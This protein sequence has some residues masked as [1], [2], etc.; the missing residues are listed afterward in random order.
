MYQTHININNVKNYCRLN[1]GA[2]DE[3]ME[4]FHAFPNDSNKKKKLTTLITTTAS[5]T[6]KLTTTTPVKNLA[7]R[8]A[9]RHAKTTKL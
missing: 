8:H 4:S 1:L 7:I 5:P 9:L 6:S 2:F 3:C